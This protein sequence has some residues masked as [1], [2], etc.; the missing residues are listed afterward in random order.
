M[1]RLTRSFLVL[2]TLSIAVAGCNTGT[3]PPDRWEAADQATREGATPVAGAE[4]TAE[5]LPAP[6]SEERATVQA[7]GAFNKFFP[8]VEKPWDIIYK[9]E[10]E[11]FAQANLERDGT[12]VAVLS[13]S[14][15]QN[16]PGAAEKFKTSDRKIDGYP[17]VANGSKGT[18]ILVGNR[19]QVQIRSS[20]D[21]FTEAD[22]EAWIKKFDLIPL[23]ALQ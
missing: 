8:E 10:K 11:G 4:G 1:P 18:A 19:F 2:L 5:A 17:A 23:E 22:R 9:Q 6:D 12:E 13:I 14:D 7:G 3:S 20:A 21:S 16:N 15:T